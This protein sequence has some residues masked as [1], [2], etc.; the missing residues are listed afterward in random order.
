MSPSINYR[1]IAI[2]AGLDA[3][4]ADHFERGV[5]GELETELRL[6]R[7]RYDLLQKLIE[8]E[9]AVQPRGEEETYRFWYLTGALP[10]PL[11]RVDHPRFTNVGKLFDAS[12]ERPLACS[13]STIQGFN[14][15]KDTLTPDQLALLKERLS[16]N[17]PEDGLPSIALTR[18]DWRSAEGMKPP[19]VNYLALPSTAYRP[20]GLAFHARQGSPVS[21]NQAPGEVIFGTDAQAMASRVWMEWRE[22]AQRWGSHNILHLLNGD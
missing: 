15:Q 21:R 14:E 11:Y 13:V 4:Q 3:N 1:H 6:C 5:G 12:S 20:G 17:I 22:N 2:A 10:T 19:S 7:E 8:K 9:E 18:R 16:R